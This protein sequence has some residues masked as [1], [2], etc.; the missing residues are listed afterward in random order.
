[1]DTTLRLGDFVFQG[2]EIPERIPLGGAQALVI[3]KLP[4]GA[5]Q[6][7]AMG[8][9]DDP[10]QWT[11]LMLGSGALARARQLDTM[12]VSGAPVVMAFLGFQYNVNIKRFSFTV[13]AFYRVQYTLELEV[14]EDLSNSSSKASVTSL[15]DAVTS[16]S[17]SAVTLGGQINDSPLSAALA[18]MDSTIKSVSNFANATQA[19]I[20]S[21]LA[22]VAAVGQRIGT[23]IASSTNT[24]NSVTTLGGILPNNPVAQQAARFS[25]QLAATSQLP[26][27]YNLQS[28]TGRITTN[29]NLVNSAQ[30]AGTQTVGGGTL[31]DLAAKSYGDATRWTAIAQANKTNDPQI[32][33]I[34]T[35]TIPKSPPDNG[36]I[37]QI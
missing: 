23:L 21:V 26:L 3:H 33:T 7:Q 8:R 16:D 32:A 12:R 2:F 6:I 30:T 20:N 15:T 28:V 4:G 17:A 22:P 36:G 34:Q 27:L 11:G 24:L 37:P 25:G 13:E 9:D 29:L 35:L 10:I 19:T 5:R 1:M 14:I 31:F 18:T